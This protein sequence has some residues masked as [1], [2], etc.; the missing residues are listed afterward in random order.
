MVT[1]WRYYYRR[2][3]GWLPVQFCMVCGGWYW[4]G[5]PCPAAPRHWRNHFWQWMPAW[6]DYCSR[7]CA[8]EDLDRL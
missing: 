5:F 8:D 4:G 3:F 2:Y 6:R 1:G 7:E